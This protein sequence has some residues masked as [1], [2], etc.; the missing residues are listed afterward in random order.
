MH[1][2]EACWLRYQQRDGFADR[3]VPTVHSQ[4]VASLA[5]VQTLVLMQSLTASC[6]DKFVPAL[7]FGKLGTTFLGS[8]HTHMHLTLLPGLWLVRD[9]CVVHF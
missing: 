8:N 5:L 9:R 4:S 7:I 3:A 6:S 2:A 1:H